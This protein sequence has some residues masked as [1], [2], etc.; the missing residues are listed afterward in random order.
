MFKK[1]ITFRPSFT[2][3]VLAGLFGFLLMLSVCM[4]TY[5]LDVS[6]NL[7]ERDIQFRGRLIEQGA[8]YYKEQCAR[9]HGADGL[10]IDGSGPGISNEAFLGKTEFREVDG[11]RVIVQT[12]PS[13]R[14]AELGYKGTLRDYVRSVIAS[15]LPIKSSNV[16]AEPHPPF[17]EAYGGP[18]RD[19]QVN[20]VT[21]FVVNWAQAPNPDAN[22]IMPPPPGGGPVATA[23]PLS[24][25]ENAGKEVYI[26]AGCTACHGIK[27]VGAQGAVGPSLSKIYTVAAE[28][29]ASEDYKTKVTGQP[30]A[31]TA[32]EY[33]IQSIYHPG[34]YTVPKCPQGACTAGVMPITYQQSISAADFK[35]MI[36]YFKT[37]K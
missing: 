9:C 6:A 4:V 37:L 7:S 16:W 14:L 8:R 36:A 5:V 19:D 21:S 1:I 15:G 31:T 22:A 10:G 28:R 12:T 27:G 17:S 3:R 24:A 35:N 13:K 20:N 23:V 30:A 33:I 29:I 25:E 2:L 26:K 11:Q 32:E 34:A 18:F